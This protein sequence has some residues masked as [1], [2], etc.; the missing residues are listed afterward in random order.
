M[1]RGTD[2]PRARSRWVHTQNGFTNYRLPVWIDSGIVAA[3]L[4][5]IPPLPIPISIVG[6]DLEWGQWSYVPTFG[7]IRWSG[8]WHSGIFDGRW[9]IDVRMDFEKL[10]NFRLSMLFNGGPFGTDK[11]VGEWTTDTRSD[12]L[13]RTTGY[14]DSRCGGGNFPFGGWVEARSDGATGR[15]YNELQAEGI[16]QNDTSPVTWSAPDDPW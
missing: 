5:D 16:D 10:A 11:F 12:E 14:V 13:N 4:V 2:W 15:H 3:Y 9:A 1:K 7:A 8:K 6:P